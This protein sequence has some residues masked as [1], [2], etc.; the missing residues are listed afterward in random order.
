MIMLRW[1]WWKSLIP[2]PVTPASIDRVCL[3]RL[4][5]QILCVT[6]NSID[7]S[8]IT[9]ALLKSR[10]LCSTFVRHFYQN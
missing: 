7:I 2:H 6:E 8:N 1:Y 10:A 5:H 4:S 3:D 9:V